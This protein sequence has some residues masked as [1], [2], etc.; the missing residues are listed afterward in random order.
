MRN[1]GSNWLEMKQRCGNTRANSV[2]N[3][4]E[5]CD[6][7]GC[8]PACTWNCLVSPDQ[9]CRSVRRLDFNYDCK[10]E[11]LLP[12]LPVVACIW[13]STDSGWGRRRDDNVGGAA[14]EVPPLQFV[15]ESLI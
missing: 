11:R 2:Q 14:L 8:D 4:R 6:L 7:C 1:T 3:N 12:L 13:K 10:I 9:A 15:S 5:I